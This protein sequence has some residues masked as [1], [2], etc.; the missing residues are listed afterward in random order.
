MARASTL[1]PDAI[2]VM[3]FVKLRTAYRT[4]VACGVSNPRTCL[5]WMIRPFCQN[6][7]FNSMSWLCMAPGSPDEKAY[8]HHLR[9]KHGL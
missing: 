3:T 5:D 8:V 6:W 1:I 7:A 2:S 9:I 4:Y